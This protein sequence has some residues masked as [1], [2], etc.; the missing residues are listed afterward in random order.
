MNKGKKV[1][2][3]DHVRRHNRPIA[4]NEVV[5]QRLKNLVS[6]HV[7]GQMSYFRIGKLRDRILVWATWLFYAVLVDLGDAVA[8][9]LKASFGRISLEM[10]FRGLYHFSVAYEKGRAKDPVK[11]FAAPENKD[12]GVLKRPRPSVHKSRISMEQP[13]VETNPYVVTYG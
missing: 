11:N 12:L 3:A 7:F 1:R 8:E 2:N 10:T 6:A 13:E 4:N 5:E 9:E